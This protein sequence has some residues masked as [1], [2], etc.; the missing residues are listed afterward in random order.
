MTALFLG[1]LMMVGPPLTKLMFKT[2]IR[3][4]PTTGA[5]NR[6]PN[7]LKPATAKALFRTLLGTSPFACVPVVRALTPVVRLPRPNPLVLRTIGMTRPLLGSDMVT[8]RPTRPPRTIPQLLI[9]VPMRGNL[10]SVPVAVLVTVGTKASVIFL[11]PKNVLPAWPCYPIRWA[12]LVLIIAAMRGDIPPDTITR[13]DTTWVMWL[14]LIALLL[15]ID[16][17]PC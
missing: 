11:C 14:T 1:A 15:A 8:F 4:R 7:E 10:V 17:G 3:G 13:L 6:S 16:V 9:E 12:M 2:V 5:L